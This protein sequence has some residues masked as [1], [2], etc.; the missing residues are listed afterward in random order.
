MNQR[1][2]KNKNNDIIKRHYKNPVELY[3]REFYLWQTQVISRE[4]NVTRIWMKSLPLNSFDDRQLG[5]SYTFATH[6]SAEG[7]RE[8][9]GNRKRNKFNSQIPKSLLIPV[10][11][12][13]RLLI[14]CKWASCLL[15]SVETSVPFRKF[16]AWKWVFSSNCCSCF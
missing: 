5:R 16:S 2:R 3:S 6:D 8:G 11:W 10:E 13:G 15:I 14:A 7:N 1:R 9:I 4:Y 12:L